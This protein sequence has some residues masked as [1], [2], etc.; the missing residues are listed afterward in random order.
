MFRG[1]VLVA[2]RALLRG[3]VVLMGIDLRVEV[4]K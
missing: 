3:D 4:L 2:E 1:L